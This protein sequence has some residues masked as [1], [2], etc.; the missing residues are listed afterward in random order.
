MLTQWLDSIRRI[1]TAGVT[2]NPT[3]IN[4]S[5]RIISLLLRDRGIDVR[6][7][8]NGSEPE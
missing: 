5:K 3:A 6:D 8:L 2:G 1:L 7:V 4:T